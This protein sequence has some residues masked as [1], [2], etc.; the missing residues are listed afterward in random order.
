MSK[1]PDLDKD[2]INL[3]RATASI[4][5]GM[6]DGGMTRE[7][8]TSCCEAWLSTLT[9]NR[10]SEQTVLGVPVNPLGPKQ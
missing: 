2:L 7:E 5:K 1:E 4:H 3:G 9:T 6:V 8:A 10:M